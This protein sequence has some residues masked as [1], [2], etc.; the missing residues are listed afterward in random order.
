MKKLYVDM[1][2]N[3]SCSSIFMKDTEIIRA[4]VTIYS[5]PVADRNR[6]YQKLADDHDVHFIYDDDN[7]SADFYTIP[8]VDIMATDSDG[9]YICTIGEMSDLDSKAPICYIDKN[10]K[11]FLI[12]E[13]FKT[14]LANADSWKMSLVPYD[15]I[16]FFASK[17]EAEKEYE[18]FELDKVVESLMNEGGESPK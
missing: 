14:F 5:M 3:N 8:Y 17:E 6:E 7:I 16:T 4:G 1:T 12:A 15:E 11:V 13:D 2:E 18:F 9:G 10:K